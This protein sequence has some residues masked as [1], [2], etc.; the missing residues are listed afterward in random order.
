[1]P[2]VIFFL[3]MQ[4]THR[5]LSAARARELDKV[6][7]QIAA[8]CRELT[9]RIGGREDTLAI[10][11]QILALSTYE[12][13]LGQARTWPYN[14][15]MLRTLFFSVLVPAGTFGARLLGDIFFP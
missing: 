2:V 5:V 14:T 12:K 4:P 7:R 10:S 3:I 9:A 8:S 15:S 1:V 11:Q 13:R 6:E